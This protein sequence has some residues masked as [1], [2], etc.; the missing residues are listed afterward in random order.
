MTKEELK[1]HQQQ[2]DEAFRLYYEWNISIQE[3]AD[4]VWLWYQSIEF[5][6]RKAN[7]Q[8][9]RSDLRY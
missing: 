5:E 6:F 1:R 3:I 9:N 8:L 7:I 4:K 2:I